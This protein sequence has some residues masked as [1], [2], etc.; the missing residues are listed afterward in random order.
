MRVSDAIVV[1]VTAVRAL[2]PAPLDAVLLSPA[3]PYAAFGFLLRNTTGTLYSRAVG[4]FDLTAGVSVASSSKWVSQILLSLL[5]VD[6]TLSPN[7]TTRGVLGAPWGA[8]PPDDPRGAI[9]LASLMSFTSGLNDSVPCAQA[10][11]PPGAT[12]ATCAADLLAG[13]APLPLP[14]TPACPASFYYAGS[15]QQL[16]SYMAVSAAGARGWNELFAARL[17]RPLGLAAA[18]LYTPVS[19]PH[20]A[21]GLFISALDYGTVLRAYFAG[22]LL[23]PDAVAS[24]EADHTRAPGTCIAYSPLAPAFVWHYGWGQWLECR[25]PGA[26]GPAGAWQPACDA[27]CAH[28]SIGLFG[29]YPSW[30]AA[31][32][33]GRCSWWP[34]APRSRPRRWARNCGPR[35]SRR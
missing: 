10:F 16:A 34:T 24:I 5:L 6:G 4:G 11:A 26:T 17:A 29:T 22:A 27:G 7:S 9:T 2:D 12:P 15:H 3:F 25:A 28:S 33:I 32:A 1:A 8:L 35:R 14:P 20:P 30:T 31:P 19:N 18:T 13:Q 23:P 21:G